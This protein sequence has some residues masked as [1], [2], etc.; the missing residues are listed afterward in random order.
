VKGAVP[1][2]VS[3]ARIRQANLSAAWM[4][5]QISS[6]YLM[7]HV[8]DGIASFPGDISIVSA[9]EHCIDLELR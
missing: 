2:P 3:S 6:A 9:I 8:I 4:Q 1:C 5:L 7:A